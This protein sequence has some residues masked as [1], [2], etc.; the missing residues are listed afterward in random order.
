MESKSNAQFALLTFNANGQ[1][2]E[3]FG[4]SFQAWGRY[5]VSPDKFSETPFNSVQSLWDEIISLRKKIPRLLPVKYFYGH[6]RDLGNVLHSGIDDLK[7]SFSPFV[8]VIGTLEEKEF[9]RQYSDIENAYLSEQANSRQTT[10]KNKSLLAQPSQAHQSKLQETSIDQDQP[11]FDWLH[12]LGWW[13][14]GAVLLAIYFGIMSV[15]SVAN[16]ALC[17]FLGGSLGLFSSAEA[18]TLIYIPLADFYEQKSI[19]RETSPYTFGNYLKGLAE[20]FGVLKSEHCGK[21]LCMSVGVIL[22]I[23]LVI[24]VSIIGTGSYPAIEQLVKFMS[25]AISAVFSLTDFGLSASATS[26]FSTVIG[27]VILTSM[28]LAVFGM[29]TRVMMAFDKDAKHQA[30]VSD[31]NWPRGEKGDQE[32]PQSQERVAGSA[33]RQILSTGAKEKRVKVDENSDEEDTKSDCNC[34]GIR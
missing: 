6:R 26:T 8:V 15:L 25:Q 12:P 23:I 17:I 16:I 27:A 30:A 21:M 22:T 4:P 14:V 28:P 11:R 34:F 18:V 33:S 13:F 3:S 24:T 29:A 1:P 20:R 19:H 31:D 2:D 9:E 32:S 5:Q 7:K 10:P